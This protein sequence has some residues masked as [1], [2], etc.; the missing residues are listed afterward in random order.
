[1]SPR[2]EP[3]Q[4]GDRHLARRLSYPWYMRAAAVATLVIIYPAYKAFARLLTVN[5]PAPLVFTVGA[6]IVMWSALPLWAMYEWFTHVVRLEQ[7][8]LVDEHL[9]GLLRRTFLRQ[10]LRYVRVRGPMLELEFAGRRYVRLRSH[11]RG[12]RELS[13][14]LGNEMVHPVKTSNP[15]ASDAT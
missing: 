11:M 4:Q 14:L 10:S 15:N 7:D 2:K 1:M 5:A 9:W 3:L 6:L 13:L 12:V 8:R